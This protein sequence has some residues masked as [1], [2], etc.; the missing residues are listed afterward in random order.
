MKPYEEV[1]EF[2]AAQGLREV[3]GFKPS[4]AARERVWDLIE[5]EKT[6]G[7]SPDEKS[8]LDQCMAVEHLMTLAKARAHHYLNGNL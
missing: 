7:I 4:E 1:V 8:E 2:I 5:R 3:I 6:T